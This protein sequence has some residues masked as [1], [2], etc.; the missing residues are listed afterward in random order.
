[1][2]SHQKLFRT[3]LLLIASL[4]LN[5]ENGWSKLFRNDYVQFELPAGW[6]CKIEGSEW[7]CQSNDPEVKKEIIVIC[8]AKQRGPED[9]I[10]K[11]REHLK[12]PRPKTDLAGK[13]YTS[14]VV[15]V[16]EKEIKGQMWVDGMH[17]GSE[18]PGFY[19]RYISTVKGKVAMLLTWSVAKSSYQK[20]LAEMNAFVNSLQALDNVGE[21]VASG[22]GFDTPHP[23]GDD[24]QVPSPAD[25]GAGGALGALAKSN[26]G[27][28]VGLGII[29]AAVVGLIIIRRRK[30]KKK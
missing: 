5:T 13:P 7:V 25:G 3:F 17:V 10:D 28:A 21:A 14:E 23:L 29:A 20:Y 16:N 22:S 15:W 18:I 30:A 1:M 11:Y 2:I 27:K 8:A 6:D 4:V 9:E 12:K 19:T 26:A 24:P